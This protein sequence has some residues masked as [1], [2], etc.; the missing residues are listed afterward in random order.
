MSFLRTLIER[1]ARNR[2]VWR[3]LENGL[4]IAVSPD[5]QLKYLGT[6]IDPDL[7]RLARD[8]VR[9][10]AVVWDVGANCGSFIFSCDH[11]ATRI[12]VEPDP[13]LARL[14]ER[15]S[16]RN[17]LAVTVV[18][19]AVGAEAG[20][21]E[22]VIARRGRASNHL[23]MVRGS[24]Q[25]GGARGTVRVTMTSL[26]ALMADY[27]PP[28]FIKIDVEGA[29]LLALQG[30]AAVLRHRPLIYIEVYAQQ[31]DACRSLL[32]A[33]GYRIDEGTNWLATP[34]D[35]GGAPTGANP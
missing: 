4:A 23:A 24:T 19:R 12:A 14:I 25:T 28:D 33:A 6:E 22:L 15:S 34:V 7:A 8:Q 2:I 31:A 35:Q 1:F 30:G 27:G 13:F 26:D 11:A 20:E 18:Q 16:G 17:G 21:A 32:L 9:P 29:E 5:S 3:K 10:G